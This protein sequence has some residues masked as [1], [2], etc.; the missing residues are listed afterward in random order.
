VKFGQGEGSQQGEGGRDAQPST[1]RSFW[2]WI[3]R[4]VPLSEVLRV[5]EAM[6]GAYARL[7]EVPQHLASLSAWAKRQGLISRRRTRPGAREKSG[8]S[9]RYPSGRSTPSQ[10]A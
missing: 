3:Y 5:H 1:L 10:E 9:R 4:V 8:A 2:W 7:L 6:Q